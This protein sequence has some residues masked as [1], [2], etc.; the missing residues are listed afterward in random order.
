MLRI[1][2]V[3]PSLRRG[4]RAWCVCENRGDYAEAIQVRRRE[5]IEIEVEA[6]G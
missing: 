2:T 5:K 6:R 4:L 3:P 1:L